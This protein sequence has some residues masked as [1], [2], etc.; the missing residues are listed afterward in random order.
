[1]TNTANGG[2]NEAQMSITEISELGAL[3]QVSWNAPIVYTTF[4]GAQAVPQTTYE[5][6]ITYSGS[7]TP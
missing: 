2:N 4:A 5:G 3:W 6:G 7:A 1:L